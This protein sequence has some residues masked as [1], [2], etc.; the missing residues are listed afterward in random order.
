VLEN[1]NGLRFHLAGRL[2]IDDW[3]GR[4]RVKMNL[5]DAAYAK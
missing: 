4:K 1:H 3:G 5:E 2:Q